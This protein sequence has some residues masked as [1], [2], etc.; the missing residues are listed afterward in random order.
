MANRNQTENQIPIEYSIREQLRQK[1]YDI[2]SNNAQS[3][4]D[5]ANRIFLDLAKIGLSLVTFVFIFSSAFIKFALPNTISDLER[6][7]FII[8]WVLLLLSLLFGLG[9]L[10]WAHYFFVHSAQIFMRATNC[11]TKTFPSHDDYKNAFEQAEKE[12]QTISKQSVEWP[13]FVQ[14]ILFIIAFVIL[15]IA[16]ANS[17]FY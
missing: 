11:W 10:I 1:N 3:M 14:Y 12:R 2:N 8:G 5:W 15:I 13:L 6:I 17:L 9:Q 7:L 4:I 16:I